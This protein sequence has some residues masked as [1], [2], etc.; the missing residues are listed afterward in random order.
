M[1]KVGPLCDEGEAERVAIWV[2]FGANR[3]V[4]DGPHAD[5]VM[6]EVWRGA[7][8][9]CLDYEGHFFVQNQF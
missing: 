5:G 8:S 9:F 6:V 4:Q 2:G 7:R 3:G 1:V